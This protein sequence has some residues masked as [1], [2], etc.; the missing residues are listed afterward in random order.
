MQTII[1]PKTNLVISP[2]SN[3]NFFFNYGSSFHSNDARVVVSSSGQRTL[4]KA[5]GYE[6]GTR[7]KLLNR[8]YISSALWLLDLQ[9]EFVYVGDEGTTELSGATRREG[10]DISLRSQIN[11]WLWADADFNFSRGRF[12]N[13]PEGENYIPLAPDFTSTGGL[14]AKLANGVET[15]LRYIHISDRPANE[16]NSITAKGTT[17]FDL[18]AS[19]KIGIIKLFLTIENIFDVEWNEAQF[20]TESRLKNEPAAISELHFTPGYPRSIKV[21]ILLN[22]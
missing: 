11:S 3:L 20:D 8:I 19:Y 5:N 13:E 6:I 18:A 12:R 2:L 15:N 1:S 14:T 22:L 9:N 7:I 4:P 16:T 17:L 21:S 10:I